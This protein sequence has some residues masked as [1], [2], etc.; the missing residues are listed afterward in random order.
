MGD[1]TDRK[2]VEHQLASQRELLE[3]IFDNIP[4]LL[5]MWNPQFQRFTLNRHAESVL[6]WTANDGD[7][8]S[9]VYPDAEYRAK[10]IEYMQSLKSGWHEWICTSKDGGHVP[11]DWANIRLSDDTMIGIGVDLRERKRAEQT[12]KESESLYRA[13][14][15]S[16]PEG[17]IYVFDHDLRFR[18]AD[19]QALQV[20]GFT[21]VGLE[22]KTIWEAT[23]EET[24][25]ILEQRFP[26]VL[27]GESLHFETALKGRFFSSNY[28][29][30]RNDQGD[31][32]AGMVVSHDITER[33]ISEQKLKESENRF[34]TMADGLPLIVWVHDVEGKQQFVNKTFMDFFGVSQEEVENDRWQM[35]LHPDEA[36]VYANEFSNCVRDQLPF[37][38]HAR[39]KRFDGQW[40]WI[41]SWARPRFSF[42]GKYLGHVGTSADITKRKQTEE[43]LKDLTKNLELRVAERT[44]VAEERSRQLQRL[45]LE[46]SNA[47]DNERKRIAMILHD[48]LQ[49]YHGALR[50]NL[51]TLLQEDSITGE[52][53]KQ[54]QHFED[55]IDQAI[56]K[57][58]SL[59]HELSP[60]VLHQSGFL[61]GLHWLVQDVQ[62]KHGQQVTLKSIPEAEPGSTA[63]TSILYRSVRELLFNA[64]KHSETK[65]ALIEADIEGDFIRISVKDHGK[66]CDVEAVK[67]RTSDA[68]GFGLFNIEERINFLGGQFDIDSIPGKGCCVTMRVPK[69]PENTIQTVQVSS[70]AI[71]KKIEQNQPHPTD[72]IRIM[73]VD[74][75]ASMRQGL[76]MLLNTN[77]DFEL[78][79]EASNGIEAVKTAQEFSP[80]VILMDVSMPEMDGIEATAIIKNDQ[81]Y[82][83]IIGL[84][85]HEDEKTEQ[86][87]I[88]AGASAYISKVAPVNKIF[89]VIR[90]RSR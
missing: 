4:I 27:A 21:R 45:A 40:R 28:V 3:G 64:L 72:Q 61:A 29:P 43:A 60:P 66:G 47:E 37:R 1:I 31:V 81:P 24:C 69:N 55:L 5:V 9:K 19:G 49:Q 89:E 56:T 80:D 26:R 51:F 52:A 39:V 30:I 58:R 86:R 62:K 46:L 76:S 70:Y 63:V 90:K 79:A 73:L 10:V 34:R 42:N 33:K 11:I 68:P 57:T 65:T 16:F 82:I 8:M 75:H 17:A 50:Y 53:K 84:S 23:D 38:A 71:P 54:L 48:D 67:A 12:L 36:E 88:A 41:E 7:F 32:I 25:K 14:A 20:L 74:D 2:Q 6:G 85:M 44:A 35:L 18:I 87:M 15:Q 13:I 83:R 22:G 78:V 59:S 77:N